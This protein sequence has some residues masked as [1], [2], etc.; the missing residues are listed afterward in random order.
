MTVSA[1]AY[2]NGF[3]GDLAALKYGEISMLS[4]DTAAMIGNAIKELMK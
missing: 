1:S 2:I 4:S 3:A